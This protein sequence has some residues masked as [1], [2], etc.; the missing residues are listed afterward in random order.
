VA[1]SV[2]GIGAGQGRWRHVHWGIVRQMGLAWLTTIPATAALAAGT[3]GLWR[4]VE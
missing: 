2:I 1:S 3:F 4:V